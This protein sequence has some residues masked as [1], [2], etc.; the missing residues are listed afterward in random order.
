MSPMSIA[1]LKTYR[2]LGLDRLE[3]LLLALP[4]QPDPADYFVDDYIRLLSNASPRPANNPPYVG[5]YG[6]GK[7]LDEYR[8]I[9]TDRLQTL[10]MPLP[11]VDTVDAKTDYIRLLSDLPARPQSVDPYINLFKL[12]DETAEVKDL[13]SSSASPVPSATKTYVTADQVLKIV[14]SQNLESRIKSLIPGLNATLDK[15]EINTDLRIAHFLAQII[16][17]SGGFRWIREIWG[18]TDQQKRYDPPSRLATMLGNTHA[19]DGKKYMGRGAIQL[20]GRSNYQQFSN[21]IAV[22]FVS[23]PEWAESPQYA[24]MVAGWYWKTRKINLPADSDNVVRVTRLINGGTIGL[25][26]R[27][28]YLDRAKQVI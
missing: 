14:G 12:P 26:E 24:I 13:A 2:Q 27:R 8:D 28:K 11:K 9:A 1:E 3:Q 20:T 23:H 15:F 16:H 18:P 19:G 22:D 17:E 5:L 6:S 25:A 10:A 7:T 4:E 21:A